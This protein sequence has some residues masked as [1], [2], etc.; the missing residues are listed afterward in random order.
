MKKKMTVRRP[1][2]RI[3]FTSLDF[4]SLASYLLA[5]IRDLLP[6]WLPGGRMQGQEFVCASLQGG[7][8]GDSCKV[9]TATGLWAD[10][11]TGEKGGDMISLYAAI[12][13]LKQGEA[14]KALATD[15]NFNLKMFE[16][17][18]PV[19]VYHYV[20]QQLIDSKATRKRM[21]IK[22]Q[23]LGLSLRAAAAAAGFS[24][25]Y[26]CDLENGKRPWTAKN[27]QKVVHGFYKIG[28]VVKP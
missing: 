17:I 9:N 21:R 26:L 22:R 16:I 24:H 8:G 1:R 23:A 10:F 19:P 15:V 7:A 4:D 20:T 2:R 27:A 28:K 12:N 11:A 14:A 3:R 25:G 18:G 13:R 6:R 5:R